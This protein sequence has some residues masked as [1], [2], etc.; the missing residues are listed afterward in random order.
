MTDF[1]YNGTVGFI[2]EY[3]YLF[4]TLNLKKQC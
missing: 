3:V 2:N 1:D 4:A